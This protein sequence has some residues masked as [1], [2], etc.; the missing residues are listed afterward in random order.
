MFQYFPLDEL[1]QNVKKCKRI[2]Q[3]QDLIARTQNIK[4]RQLYVVIE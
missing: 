1:L 3:N 2:E 4:S